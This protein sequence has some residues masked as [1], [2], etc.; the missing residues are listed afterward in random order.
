MDEKLKK[1]CLGKT[2]LKGGM[3]VKQLLALAKQYGYTGGKTRAEVISFLCNGWP[4]KKQLKINDLPAELTQMILSKL[5]PTSLGT[6]SLVNRQFKDHA[7]VIEKQVSRDS[8]IIKKDNIVNYSLLDGMS[9][10]G[11]KD[12]IIYMII[13]EIHN[14][15]DVPVTQRMDKFRDY[16]DMSIFRRLVHVLWPIHEPNTQEMLEYFARLPGNVG[17]FARVLLEE[18]FNVFR[19]K[20]LAFQHKWYVPL[21]DLT[22]RDSDYICC[23]WLV[24]VG[25]LLLRQGMEITSERQRREVL[26]K[27]VYLFGYVMQ[28]INI[29]LKRK[30]GCAIL[31]LAIVLKYHSSIDFTLTQARDMTDNSV[32]MEDLITMTCNILSITPSLFDL[33]IPGSDDFLASDPSND[34]FNHIMSYALSRPV[35][36]TRFD[37]SLVLRERAPLPSI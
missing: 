31:S 17:K 29:P 4:P 32:N 27:S 35:F 10:R 28:S 15:N 9:K 1:A 19:S 8:S 16:I 12:A 21:L 25:D 26:L 2:S 5:D 13:Y 36:G 23:E 30:Q 11:N 34:T 33:E 24:E 20:T 6:A 18:G 37:P 7:K 3:N 14:R 22:P